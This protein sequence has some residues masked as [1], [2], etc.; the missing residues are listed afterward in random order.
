MTRGGKRVTGKRGRK[1]KKKKRKTKDVPDVREEERLVRLQ[2]ARVYTVRLNLIDVESTSRN[3]SRLERLNQRLLINHPSSS[4]VDDD[5]R[6]LHRLELRCADSVLRL[7][8]ER[9][10]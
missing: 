6:L 7:R 2:Q 5:R 1:G 8:V 10:V 3:L 9:E 4:G